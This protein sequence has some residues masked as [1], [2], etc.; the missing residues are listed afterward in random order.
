M[1]PVV[2]NA[3]IIFAVDIIWLIAMGG[4]FQRVVARIQGGAPAKY[5]LLMAIPVY[6]ALGYLLTVATSVRQ[7]FMI[8]LAVYA[9]FDFTMAFMFKDYPA[10]VVLMDTVWGGILMASAFYISSIYLN[11]INYQVY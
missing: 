6:L 8:G 1:L 10:L 2:Q 9:V 11:Q 5:N 3:A 4:V 7:A